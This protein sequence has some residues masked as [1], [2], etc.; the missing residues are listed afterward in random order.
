MLDQW[1]QGDPFTFTVTGPA[2]FD[3]N[4]ASKITVGLSKL[5]AFGFEAVPDFTKTLN[6]GVTVISA[7][8]FTV[9]IDEA[10]SIGLEGNYR[11]E[12]EVR[13]ASNNPITGAESPIP[14]LPTLIKTV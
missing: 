10:D 14:I 3:L 12:F 8:Q 6:D 4:D 7:T 5:K 11:I 1:F 2:D 9:L 13:D